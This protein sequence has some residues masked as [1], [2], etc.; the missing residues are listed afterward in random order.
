MRGSAIPDMD[1]SMEKNLSD[2]QRRTICRV[3]F[4]LVCAL[5]TFATVYF[6]THQR[7]AN[8][9][10]QLL[11]AE[12]GVETSIGVVETPRPGEMLFHDVKLYGDDGD[13][14]FESVK[15]KVLIGNENR[16][17]FQNLI[18]ITRKGLSEFLDE[19]PARLVKTR[20]NFKPWIVT[21]QDVEIEDEDDQ[22]F[23]NRPFYLSDVNV[24]IRSGG[25]GTHLTASASN[26]GTIDFSRSPGN[27]RAPVGQLEVRIDT[28]R[29]PVPCWLAKDWFPDLR[30]LGSQA[31][32]SGFAAIHSSDGMAS[33]SLDGDFVGVDLD[34][35]GIDP[36]YVDS[37]RSI[38]LQQLEMEDA[39]HSSGNAWLVH[40]DFGQID[41]TRYFS[42]PSNPVDNPLNETMRQALLEVSSSSVIRQ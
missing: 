34:I 7:T 2:N 37:A 36:E 13:V 8:D 15:A 10:A 4:L 28:H 9:W 12:L 22:N 16:I 33:S 5:P 21:F 18:Q 41:L 11:K 3:L 17:E 1:V 39:V 31:H 29:N 19:A 20:A 32:F 25:N 30:Q 23:E 26:L 42:Q 35:P 6:A 24:V 27:E 14:I 38:F 40:D